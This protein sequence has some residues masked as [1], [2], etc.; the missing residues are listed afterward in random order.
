[1]SVDNTLAAEAGMV[2]TINVY[3]YTGKVEKLVDGAK[4]TVRGAISYV[5]KDY[6][7]ER[8]Q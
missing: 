3:T 1:M 4:N 2:K 5:G 8:A 7:V 6:R